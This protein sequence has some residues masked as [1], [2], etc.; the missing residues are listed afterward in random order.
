[1]A[2]QV[3][4]FLGGHLDAI[5]GNSDTLVM[6]GDQMRILAIASHETFPQL[7]EI[8]TFLELGYDFVIGIERGVGLP[9]GTP[10][11]IRRKLSDGFMELMQRPD[12]QQA[13]FDDGFIPLFMDM[14]ESQRFIEEMTI[15]YSALLADLL[16]L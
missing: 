8:P 7:P 5:F 3:Q 14:D 12:I 4:S 6:H 1:M 13:M 16:D 11:E 15:K 2:P 9:P 10:Y